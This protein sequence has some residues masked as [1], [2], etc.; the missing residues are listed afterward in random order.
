M[1]ALQTEA[2]FPD[3][4]PRCTLS[5]GMKGYRPPQAPLCWNTTFHSYQLIL[6]A[7]MGRFALFSIPSM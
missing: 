5:T 6:A 1:L 4:S 7:R 2:V 3:V